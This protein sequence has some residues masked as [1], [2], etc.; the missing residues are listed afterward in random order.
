MSDLLAIP[1]RPHARQGRGSLEVQLVAGLSAIVSAHSSSPLKLLTPISRGPSVWA[2][3]G[4][5]G[6]GFV[7]GDEIEFSLALGP[8][9][10]CFLGTQASTE[11]YRSNDNRLCT[12]HLQAHI[13]EGALLVSAP[14]PIQAF[15][16]SCY[17]QRQDF[18][19]KTGSS[20]V[21]VDWLTSGRAARGERWSFSSFHSR[22][23][24]Y[25][26]GKQI[27]L[28][29]LFLS[30]EDGPLDAQYR[31]GRFNVLAMVLVIGEPLRTEGE[32]LLGRIASLPVTRQASLVCSANPIE[33]GVLVRLAGQKVE[34]VAA[35][36]GT[37]R[38]FRCPRSRFSR[39]SLPRPSWNPAL[40]KF[41]PAKSSLTLVENQF[42]SPLRTS[43]TARSRSAAITILLRPMP[44]C[45]STVAKLTAN[46]S[47]F[48]PAL[49]SGS[50]PAKPKPCAW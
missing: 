26:E 33:R 47:T 32:K 11:I 48:P 24:V 22:N 17:Q 9:S 34:D 38:S 40:A 16:G 25:L 42:H 29:S 31:L 4:S 13:G 20:L 1:E 39:H 12:Y 3:L 5:L 8:Q 37:V 28:D 10:R 35:G 49:Q 50:N 18:L 43:A 21:L 2:C 23:E 44:S 36:V 30:S 19:L 15:S 6:G 41:N 14:D 7:V 46:A 45:A 27:I